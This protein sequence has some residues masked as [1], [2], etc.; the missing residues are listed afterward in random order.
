MSEPTPIGP[1]RRASYTPAAP[2][3]LKGD[4]LVRARQLIDLYPELRSALIP[5]CHLAQ[6]QDGW[7]TPEAMVDIAGLVGVTPGEVL[8]TASFYDMLHTEPVGRHVV[9][10]CTNIACLLAGAVELLEHAENSLDIGSGGT[11]LDGMITLQEAGRLRQGPVRSGQP[12]LRWRPDPGIVR[13]AHRRAPVRC[14]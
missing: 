3:H 5:L 13:P 12:P 8:G 10:V 6:E 7:L 1:P 2:T 9:A 11:T 14:P 4:I